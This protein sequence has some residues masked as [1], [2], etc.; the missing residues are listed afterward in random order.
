LERNGA[1]SGSQNN[2]IILSQ[3]GRRRTQ[4]TATD[5]K[6]GLANGN[7]GTVQAIDGKIL[8]VKLGGRAGR[9]VEIDSE[10]F[11]GIHH[12]YPRWANDGTIAAVRR[13]NRML[14]FSTTTQM[15]R[16]IRN[17]AGIA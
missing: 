15:A 12:G 10:A 7:A 14:G 9:L 2:L 16:D 8:T 6:R 3:R 5:K 4:I 1:G 17:I 11:Q 13:L